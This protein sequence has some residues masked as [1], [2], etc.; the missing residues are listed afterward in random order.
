MTERFT[1][2]CTFDDIVGTRTMIRAGGGIVISTRS[3]PVMGKDG[4]TVAGFAVGYDLP[5]LESSS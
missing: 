5:V 2:Y 3:T 4:R 1:T